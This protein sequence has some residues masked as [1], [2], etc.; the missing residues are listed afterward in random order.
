MTDYLEDIKK[1]LAKQFGLDEESIEED[2]YLEA[3][4]NI[5]ELDMEDFVAALEDKYQITIPQEDYSKFK[6]VVDIANYL[7]ESIDQ[8]L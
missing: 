6:K 1:M 5:S 4:L 7:Y 3:D 2:S 8:T